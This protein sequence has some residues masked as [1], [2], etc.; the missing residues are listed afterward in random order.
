MKWC[1]DFLQIPPPMT[2]FLTR[3]YFPRLL[4]KCSQ[5]ETKNLNAWDYGGRGGGGIPHLNHCTLFALTEIFYTL[6]SHKKLWE[7]QKQSALLC[8]LSVRLAFN[9]LYWLG[10]LWTSDDPEILILLLL[11]PEGRDYR[12]PPTHSAFSVLGIKPRA[13]CILGKLS[14]CILFFHFNFFVLNL[15]VCLCTICMA[16]THRV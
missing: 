5:V 9:T 13:Y 12:C 8:V 2:Y 4:K 3:P 14:I 1:W 11:P 10:W 6:F 7:H 15:L 16:G